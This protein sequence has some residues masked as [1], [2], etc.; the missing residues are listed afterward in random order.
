M[1]KIICFGKIKEQCIKDCINDYIKRIKKFHNI[2]IIEL[3]DETKYDINKELAKESDKI[4]NLITNKDYII[5]LDQLGIKPNSIELSNIIDKSFI[6]KPNLV[7]IIGS[8]NGI[9]KSIKDIA[10]LSISFSNLTFPHQLFRVILLE[11]IYRS[12]KIINNEEYHK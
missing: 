7:F 3:L 12:F 8:S 6:N 10:N 1:I 9:D 4:L 5:V 2:E 11:Q